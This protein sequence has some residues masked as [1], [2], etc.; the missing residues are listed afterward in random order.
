MTS[1]ESIL[2]LTQHLLENYGKDPE[3]TA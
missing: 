2:W 3:I 1:S